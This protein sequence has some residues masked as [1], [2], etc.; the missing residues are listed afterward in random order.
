MVEKYPQPQCQCRAGI[1]N[2]SCP[3]YGQAYTKAFHVEPP[4]SKSKPY[5][6]PEDVLPGPYD[7]L[8]GAYEQSLPDPYSVLPGAYDNLD[9]I[10]GDDA[11]QG[12]EGKGVGGR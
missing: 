8:K 12:E 10:V 4:K 7:G 9:A 1:V 3:F 2:E 5:T 6:Y 11:I